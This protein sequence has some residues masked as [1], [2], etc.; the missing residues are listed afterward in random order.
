MESR[1][2]VLKDEAVEVV[3]AAIKR[4]EDFDK[5]IKAQA[6]EDKINN[7]KQFANQL[8]AASDESVKE[9][10]NLQSK[11]QKHQASV[12]E[13]AANT[14]RIQSIIGMGKGAIIELNKTADEFIENNM[15]GVYNIKETRNTIND[16]F[17]KVRNQSDGRRQCLQEASTVH[18]FICDLEDEETQIRYNKSF[19][20]FDLNCQNLHR[21]HKHFDVDLETHEPNVKNIQQLGA[22][23]THEVGNPDI[24]RK[25]A[26]LIGHWDSLKQATNERTKK[27]DEF[28]TYHDWASSLN[29]ENPWI[30]ERL[31]IMNNPGTGTTLVFVQA[32]QKKH[33][34]FESDF[35]VQNE[36]CQEILQQG[37]RLV[38]QNNH[39]SPQINKGMN[40][41]Q[42]TLNRLE[43][44]ANRHKHRLVEDAALLPFM[45]KADVVEIWIVCRLFLS[46]WSSPNL[47]NQTTYQCACLLGHTDIVQC[48]LNT[49][50][51][52]DQSYPGG[53]SMSTMRGAFLFA[54]QSR[55]MPTITALLNAGAAVDKLGS[56]SLSY[57]NSFFP[58]IHAFGSSSYNLSAA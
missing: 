33:E 36:R 29:E 48:I 7:L 56:C 1:E 21:K 6:S 37:H 44:D 27:L 15:F 17:Q 22:Q 58:G 51:P 32:L 46:T 50:I 30:K 52:P 47:E 25:S 19:Y 24:E 38:E 4:H 55:S 28:I 2:K 9:T 13:L 41:L 57:A 39:L 20:Y 23:L 16:R 45:W 12:A 3:E 35:I 10:Q 43:T 11:S 42:D 34:S 14:D 5:T 18:Q 53:N 40:Y 54:C 49:G 8:T 31:H 26:D